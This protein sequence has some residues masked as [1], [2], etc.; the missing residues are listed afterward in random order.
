MSSASQTS[1][2]ATNLSDGGGRRWWGWRR[3]AR[4]KTYR[5]TSKQTAWY[6]SWASPRDAAAHHS[7][8]QRE[9][10]ILRGVGRGILRLCNG[11]GRGVFEDFDRKG[12]SARVSAL[13]PIKSGAFFHEGAANP[14]G[15]F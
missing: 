5:E 14:R 6:Y 9:Q 12:W 13:D 10:C 3:R 15:A 1:A 4:L 8:L 11:S 7:L 2:A